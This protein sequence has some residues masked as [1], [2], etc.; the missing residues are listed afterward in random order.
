MQ[1]SKKLLPLLMSGVTFHY[2][3][4]LILSWNPEIA[5]QGPGSGDDLFRTWIQHLPINSVKSS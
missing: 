1:Q 2:T 3:Q 5:G 4:I